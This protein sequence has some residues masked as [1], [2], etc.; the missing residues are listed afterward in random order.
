MED[1]PTLAYRASYWGTLMGIPL[2]FAG[3]IVLA[4]LLWAGAWP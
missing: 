1:R 2:A 3:L 4:A